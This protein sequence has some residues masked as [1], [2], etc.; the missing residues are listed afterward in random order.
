MEEIIREINFTRTSAQIEVIQN[1]KGWCKFLGMPC[2]NCPF[3][4]P[5]YDP[6]EG[7]YVE[8]VED[9]A[10]GKLTFEGEDF[11]GYQL[12]KKEIDRLSER[13]AD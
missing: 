2:G 9:C 7:I 5:P 6:V 13:G 3:S 1:L 4:V 8:G 10:L 12:P 11:E